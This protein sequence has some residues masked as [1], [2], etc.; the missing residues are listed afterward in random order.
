MVVVQDNTGPNIWEPET[1]DWKIHSQITPPPN[2]ILIRKK[3]GD[4][5][6]CTTLEDELR[7]RGVTDLVILGAM[8]EFSIRATPQRAL[9][10]CYRVILVSD[11]H[12]TLDAFDGPA[13]EHIETLN[14]EVEGA[15]RSGLPV[16]GAAAEAVVRRFLESTSR[17]ASGYSPS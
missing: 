6:R 9:L 4:A 16:E 12:S 11:T 7:S 17:D 1:E 15:H 8:S 13:V 10:K 14:S 5:F 2:A 3:F